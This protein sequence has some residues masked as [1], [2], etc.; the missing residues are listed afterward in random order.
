DALLARRAAR[1]LAVSPLLAELLASDSARPAH[2]LVLPWRVGH[3]AHPG[4]RSEARARLG[5][6]PPHEVVLYAGNLD[7]YQGL[8]TLLP[9]L[10]HACAQRPQLRWL[11]ATESPRARFAQAIR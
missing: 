5:F 11:V 2:A 1:T 4:E 7:R 9:E 10:A 8:D 6:A 3:P